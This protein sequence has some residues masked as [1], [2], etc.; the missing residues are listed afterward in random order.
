MTL[1]RK[2]AEWRRARQSAHSR[3]LPLLPPPPP[4][5]LP[6]YRLRG[7]SSERDWI[8]ASPVE[9]AGM[10]QSDAALSAL[11]AQ[12]IRSTTGGDFTRRRDREEFCTK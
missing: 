1:G 12:R 5:P 3:V 11:G 8:T 6:H 7:G 2:G 4:P 9:A 10:V